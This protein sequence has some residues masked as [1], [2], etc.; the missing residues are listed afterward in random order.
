[1]SGG[2]GVNDIAAFLRALQ[3]IGLGP[4]PGARLL[5]NKI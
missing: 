4:R 3:G 2:T 1:M 5:H